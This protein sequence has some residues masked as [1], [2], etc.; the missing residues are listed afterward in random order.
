MLSQQTRNFLLAMLVFLLTLAAFAGGYLARE[1]QM[2]RERSGVAGSADLQLFHEAW[3]RVG[4]SFF[5]D[6]PA[7]RAVTYGAIRGSLATLDD[8][9]TVFLEPVARQHESDNLRGNYGGIGVTLM[10][11]E[12]SGE[13]L[14]EPLPDNPASEMGIRSGDV[15]LAVDGVAISADEPVSAIAARIRGEV[16]KVVVLTVRGV[17]SAEIADIAI[18][19]TEILIPSVVARLLRDQ[20]EIGYVQLTRFS[21]ESANEIKRAIESLQGE[22]ANRF[23]LDLRD[24]GGGLLD[25]AVLVSGLFM[26]NEVVYH[27]LTRGEQERSERTARNAPFAALPL[28][29]LVN[30]GTASASEIVAGALH[31]N[32]R[33]PLFGQRTFG[34]GSVQLVYD[35]SDGS[36]VHVTWARWLTPDRHP[37]DQNGLTPTFEVVPSQAALDDGRDETLEQA[38]AWLLRQ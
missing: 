6:L 17:E 30:G 11:D 27:Q 23:V 32:D 21:G 3:D 20:P 18:I 2:Q 8:P 7:G 24:N 37:I 14:L 16:G 34:K 9:Y 29:L 25:A 36:S 15:L 19:R 26:G 28:A 10:R 22:G 33:A 35:L 1:V 13:V 5:G 31:D 38:A 12:E 4:E